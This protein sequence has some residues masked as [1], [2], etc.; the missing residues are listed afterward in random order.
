MGK[1]S[2]SAMATILGGASRR[3]TLRP[4][5]GFGLA[6]VAAIIGLAGC[7]GTASSPT[8]PSAPPSVSASAIS[9]PTS[10]PSA[11]PALSPTPA[12]PLTF[13]PTGSMH[14]ARE[15]ATATLL[16]NGKVLIAGGDDVFDVDKNF[17]A[18]AEIYDPATGKFTKTGSMTAARAQATAVLLSD[19]RVLIAGGSGCA[20]PKHCT[21]VRGSDSLTSAEIYDPVTGKFTRTGSMTSV[22]NNP[23]A[24]LLPDG[25]VLIAAFEPGVELYD[26]ATGRFT[27]L[28]KG[29][30]TSPP[31]TA[32]LLPNGK[33]LVI[34]GDGPP[35][36]Y[37]EAS[38]KLASISPA[39]PPGAPSSTSTC[40]LYGQED[41]H[42][43]TPLPDGR[44]LLFESGHL[45]TL[46]PATGF[47]VDAGFVT[48][49]GQWIYPRATLLPDGRVLFE[50]GELVPDQFSGG[51]STTTAVLYDPATRQVST[52]S[53]HM[54]RGGQTAT[55][56]ADGSVLIAGGYDVNYEPLGSAELFKP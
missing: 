5:L 1:T 19:G 33:V 8:G 39:L 28:G 54:A 11:T 49:G 27:E 17:Y 47:C 3:R 23:A 50:G 4:S 42:T 55:L 36:L 24:V 26:P 41:A 35:Q 13:V 20:D 44:V 34:T 32:T 9:S 51:V 10:K 46:D 53:M 22:T 6:G 48:T 15:D 18:S 40:W 30:P 29:G 16:K 43:A 45:E 52:G 21:N 7:G 37:D 2:N 14:T 12:Q 56:L 38:G 25:K 31:N